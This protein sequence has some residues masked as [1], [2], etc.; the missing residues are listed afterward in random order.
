M[1]RAAA[2]VSSENSL[3]RSRTIEAVL[4]KNHV[5]SIGPSQLKNE[6]SIV[7]EHEDVAFVAAVEENGRVGLSA[8]EL[9]DVEPSLLPLLRLR[10]KVKMIGGLIE[11]LQGVWRERLS[12]AAH[13]EHTD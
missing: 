6:A 12:A 11:P 8:P 5:G 1:N 10:G 4:G 13:K 9:I 2:E 7:V 3:G